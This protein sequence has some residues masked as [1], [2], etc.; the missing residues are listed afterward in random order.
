MY[1]SE[2]V[3]YFFLSIQSIT[4]KYFGATN[5]KDLFLYK[6]NKTHTCI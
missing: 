3:L 4:I 6:I 2:N 5:C 1:F